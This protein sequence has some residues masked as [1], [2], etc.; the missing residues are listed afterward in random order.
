VVEEVVVRCARAEDLGTMCFGRPC[1]EN[2][3]GSGY[4]GR[5]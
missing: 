5:V 3:V 1:S 2:H 4:Q